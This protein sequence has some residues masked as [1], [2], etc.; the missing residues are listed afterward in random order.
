[1]KDKVYLSIYQTPEGHQYSHHDLFITG[2]LSNM[3][4]H[5]L[6]KNPLKPGSISIIVAKSSD[7][8]DSESI[9]L[10]LVKIKKESDFN[11]WKGYDDFCC[12]DVDFINTKTIDY[13]CDDKGSGKNRIFD[14]AR[15]IGTGHQ[16]SA[17]CRDLALYLFLDKTHGFDNE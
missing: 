6:K 3:L 10:A 4:G 2:K 16:N 7:P 14:I 5:G 12:Y 17:N 15:S 1:M 9:D 11:P 8:K 13:R